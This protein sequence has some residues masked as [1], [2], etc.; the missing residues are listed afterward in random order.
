[1]W[2]KR[3]TRCAKNTRHANIYCTL[4]VPGANTLWTST[5][6]WASSYVRVHGYARFQLEILVFSGV[7]N[8][9]T[10]LEWGLP[11]YLLCDKSGEPESTRP[12]KL[13][14]C[15]LNSVNLQYVREC[16]A[17]MSSELS[18]GHSFVCPVQHYSFAISAVK[19]F[20]SLTLNWFWNFGKLHL[21]CDG[22]HA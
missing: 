18:V 15:S 9:V 10:L 1:M 14:F 21:K 20:A 7:M 12:W 13:Q 2:N 5:G 11:S 19:I 22:A 16:V 17:V 3:F 4:G 8:S 6:R